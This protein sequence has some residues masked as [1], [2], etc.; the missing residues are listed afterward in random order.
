MKPRAKLSNSQ[1]L[2]TLI[3]ASVLGTVGLFCVDTRVARADDRFDG[4][5]SYIQEAMQQWQVPGLAIAIVKDGQ[6]VLA[7]GYGVCELGTERLVTKDSIFTIASCTKSFTAACI[8]L[9]V[10]EGKLNWDDPVR[11]HLPN[12]ELADPYV[13]EHVT[14]RDL[15]CHRTGLVRGDLLSVK[16]DLSREEILSRTKFLSQA[17]PFRTKFLY[18]NVMYGVLGEIV[19]QKSGMPWEEFVTQRII[20]PLKMDSATVHRGDV[21]V[22][23]LAA[24]HRRYDGKVLTLQKP[25]R[26]ELVAPAA[27]IHSS[28]VDMSKW[29]KLHLQE[30]NSNGRQL[31]KPDTVREMHA[32][33]QSIPLKRN[34]NANRYS[35]QMMG[36]GLGWFVRDYRGRKII[37]HGGAWG[38]ETAIVPEEN[39]AVVV[40]SNLDHNGLV[41]MLVFDVID[42]YL[43]GPEL[44]WTKKDKWDTWL[45]IGGPGH[46]ER[47]RDEQQAQLDKVRVAGTRPSLPLEKYA[48]K[49]ESELYG[50]LFV[51][52]HGDRLAVQFGDHSA[53]LSHWQD[54]SFLGHAVVE[55]FLDWLVKF[56]VTE[57][58]VSQLE[59][60]S[61]GW[62][63]PDERHFFKRAR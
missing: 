33:H 57:G 51:T 53:E 46:L 45:R 9:L 16:G 10:D 61:I 56:Q 52:Q 12:F 11:Q 44:A 26:D 15:L 59:V 2:R 7:R 62:K 21:P 24:R 58:A 18:S 22:E 41:W 29:L 43:V 36:T 42:A 60:V 48:G 8:G 32:I 27:V 17:A 37:Q 54:D 35:A 39:L 49:Y 4:M 19:A 40:L 1:S 38:A 47:V 6:T 20:R 5:D 31:L 55:S 23:Q 13:T 28:V 3:L 25:I 14:I 63:D 30:G 50:N 34:A